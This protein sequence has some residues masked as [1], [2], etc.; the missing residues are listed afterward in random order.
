MR[1]RRSRAEQLLLRLGKR[2]R[3]QAA[4]RF[5]C[6]PIRRQL[7]LL[8][9]QRGEPCIGQTEDLVIEERGFLID[10]GQE[11]LSLIAALLVTSV[12]GIAQVEINRMTILS[13]L[14][15]IVELKRAQEL[16][17]VAGNVS[18]HRL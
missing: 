15:F 17:A 11:R 9:H 14:H 16:V 12:D 6:V 8:A 10:F 18:A 1:E 7:R 3:R 4:D 5:N 13:D 2:V